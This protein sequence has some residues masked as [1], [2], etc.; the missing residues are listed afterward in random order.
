MNRRHLLAAA[1]VAALAGCTSQ[2]GPTTEAPAEP[3]PPGAKLV[4]LKL[5]GMT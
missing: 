2:P 4:V 5:P 3:P 1:L